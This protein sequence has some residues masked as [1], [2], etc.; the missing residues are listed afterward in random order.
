MKIVYPS[1]VEDAYSIAKQ[2]GTIAPGKVNDVKA[3]IYRIM[4]H[5]GML[6]ENGNPTQKAV[7]QGLVIGLSE[8]SQSEPDTLSGF[9]R[10][11]PIYDGYSDDHFRKTSMGWV[12]DAYVMR[13]VAN[14]VLDS[15]DSTEEQRQTAYSMLQQL[16]KY[17]K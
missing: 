9:K 6:T 17:P 7:D 16:E 3:Q 15:P 4:V 8:D 2:A 13:G 11:Y 10:M 1:L 12:I 5:E 14:Q